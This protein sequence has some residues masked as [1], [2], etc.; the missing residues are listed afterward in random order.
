MP[1]DE[2][3]LCKASLAPAV[4]LKS[5]ILGQL[6]CRSFSKPVTFLWLWNSTDC[7][8]CDQGQNVQQLEGIQ[9]S[10]GVVLR[11]SIV[12]EVTAPPQ[13]VMRTRINWNTSIPINALLSSL[14]WKTA[15]AGRLMKRRWKNALWVQ[16][17]SIIKTGLNVTGKPVLR[18]SYSIAYPLSVNIADRVS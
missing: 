5:L 4:G 10:Q 12:G 11:L 3:S 18:T 6:T 7:S 8:W 2:F 9:R 14:W 1:K 13:R 17:R 15:S 16:T